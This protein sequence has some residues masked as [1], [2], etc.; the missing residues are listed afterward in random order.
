MIT[1]I[2]LSKLT[3]KKRFNSIRG[4]SILKYEKMRQM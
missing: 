3:F 1:K 2:L 4:C